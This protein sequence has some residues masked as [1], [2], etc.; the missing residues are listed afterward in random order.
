MITTAAL[1]F[2]AVLGLGVAVT[3]ALTSLGLHGHGPGLLDV[4][5]EIVV[6]AANIGM[7]FLSSRVLTPC[8]VTVIAARSRR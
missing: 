5:G 4:A 7:F 8:H 3:T 2:L 6:A 1:E